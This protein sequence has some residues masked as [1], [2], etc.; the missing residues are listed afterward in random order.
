MALDTMWGGSVANDV[1][2]YTEG[3]DNAY[4]MP[5]VML[6]NMM[7]DQELMAAANGNHDQDLVNLGPGALLVAPAIKGAAGAV[8]ARL[9]NKAMNRGKKLDLMEMWGTGDNSGYSDYLQNL[10]VGDVAAGV[11]ANIGYDLQ[12]EGLMKYPHPKFTPYEDAQG[13]VHVDPPKDHSLQ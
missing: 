9:A 11:I 4:G 2:A 10:Q 12:K 13:Y 7:T 5:D 8:G 6:Q 3:M 1:A